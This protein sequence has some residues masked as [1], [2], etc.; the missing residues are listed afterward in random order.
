MKQI[1]LGMVVASLF[2]AAAAKAEVI[3]GYYESTK[4]DLS[5]TFRSRL[6]IKKVEFGGVETFYG[7][8]VWGA[9]YISLYKI[10]EIDDSTQAWVSIHQ[11][12]DGILKTDMDQQATYQVT[13]IV[14][15]DRKNIKDV[16][17]KFQWTRLTPS[18]GPKTPCNLSPNFKLVSLEN[19]WVEFSQM[20][21]NV[22]EGI[23]ARSKN[24][25]KRI[26]KDQF[27]NVISKKS[28]PY[29]DEFSK[30]MKVEVTPSSTYRWNF[31]ATNIILETVAVKDITIKKNSLNTE[32]PQMTQQYVF[33]GNYIGI[34][35]IPGVL[36]LRERS[37]DSTKAS[38][39]TTGRPAEMVVFPIRTKKSENFEMGAMYLNGNDCAYVRATFENE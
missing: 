1:W 4:E 22:F 9:N 18:L 13:S 12:Q 20:S 16:D 8:L 2:F 38:S 27:G 35:V 37:L 21:Q 39:F 11:G 30:E 31:N 26:T 36:L 25:N 5:G 15:R 6:Y 23:R 19:Q 28:V 29:K 10:E 17:L 14:K 3:P 7:L 34:E 24:R 32:D 33:N